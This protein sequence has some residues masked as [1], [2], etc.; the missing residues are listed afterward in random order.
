MSNERHRDLPEAVAEETVA[1]IVSR[2]FTSIPRSDQRRWGEMY[3]RGLL[4]VEGKK[5]MRA[6]AAGAGGGVE[7]SL[8]QFITKSPWHTAPVRRELARLLQRTAPRAWVVQPLVIVK[9]GQHSVGVHRQWVPQIGRYVN[10][11]RAMGVWLTSDRASCPVDWRLALPDSWVAEPGLRRRASIPEDVG[12]CP[13]EQCA[14]DAVAR[15]TEEWDL[16]ARPVVMDLRE[17]DATRVCTELLRRRTPFVVRIDPSL[18]RRG[19]GDL[20]RALS[21]RCLPVEWY[22][23]TAGALRATS[24]GTTTVRLPLP[25]APGGD[26]SDRADLVLLGAWTDP[27]RRAPGEYWLSNLTR[28]RVGTLYRTAALAR[29]A[30]RDMAEIADPLGLRDFEGRSFRGWHHHM[31][32]V[33]LAQAA[34]VLSAQPADAAAPA[35]LRLP[36]VPV[37]PVGPARPVGHGT[38]GASAA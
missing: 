29:K 26:G 28:T 4:S 9:V 16:P 12:S 20:L 34:S 35:P 15:M 10:C 32:M 19:S 30:E 3:M 22:D 5:T 11:Q 37:R 23:H 24:V 25:D 36:P 6:L 27:N 31:T 2:T 1:E 21:R 7:Q 18:L 13:P 17:S 38:L 14:I 33:S 8:Y